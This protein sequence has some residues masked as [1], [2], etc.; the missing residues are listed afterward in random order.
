ML[1]NLKDIYTMEKNSSSSSEIGNFMK[2]I[3]DGEPPLV[4]LSK[5]D[6]QSFLNHIK[7]SDSSSDILE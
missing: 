7:D 4:V 3:I 2:R 5:D 6:K 1:R